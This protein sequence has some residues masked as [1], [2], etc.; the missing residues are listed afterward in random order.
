MISW[1]RRTSRRLL[2]GLPVLLLEISR[3]TGAAQVVLDGKFG[4]SGPVTGPNYAI[5]AG[6]GAVRG[7]NLFQSFS[8]FNLS[9]GEVATFSGPVG[10]QNILSRVTGG[11]P[12]SINGTIRSQIAGANFFLINPNGVIFGPSAAID[13]SGSFAAS[14]A[15]Y[16]KLA[17]GARFVASLDADDSGLSTAPVAAFGFLGPSAGGISVQQGTLSVLSGRTISLVG[18]D[19]AVDGG[20]IQSPQGRINVV[21]V[22]SAGEVP[23]DPAAMTVA[24]FNAA[25]PQQGQISF[26]NVARVDASGNGGGRIVIRGGRLT[27]DNS[28]VQSNTTG[29]GIGQGIDIAVV[30]D[31]NLFNLGQ[32][33]SLSTAGLGNGGNINISAQSILLN[34]G[35]LMDENFFP[36]TQISTATGDLFGGG[37]PGRGGDIVIQTGSLELVNSAQISSATFGL[38]DAGRIDITA[39]SVRLDAQLF[40]ATQIAANSQPFDGIGG[41]AGD[42][43]IRTDTLDILNGASLFAN[44]FGSGNG[45]NI[46]VQAKAINLTGYG[47]IT[48][49]TYGTGNGGNV[50][51]STDSLLVDSSFIQAVTTLN[52]PDPTLGR[53]GNVSINAGSIEVRNG[54]LISATTLGSGIGGTINV[55][56][57]SIRL[58]GDS[59]ASGAPTGIR[60]ASGQNLGG[61]VLV[62]TGNGGDIVIES[63]TPGAL[64]LIVTDGAQISTETLGSGDGG[65]IDISVSSLQLSRGGNISSA[66]SSSFVGAGVA[67]NVIVDAS[68]AVVLT[69]QALITTA[70]VNAQAGNISITA[71]SEVQIS[72]S[73]VTAQAGPGAAGRGGNIS[74]TADSINIA[75]GGLIS[76]TTLGDGAGGTINLAADS[77]QLTGD[78]GASGLPTGIRAAS[79]QNVGGFILVGTGN[80]GDIVIQSR[81]PG[82]LDLVVTDGAQISTETLGSGDGGRIDISA[83]SLQ[84]SSGGNISSASSDAGAAGNIT[85]TTSGSVVLTDQGLI[86]TAAPNAQGGDITVTAGDQIQLTDSQITAQAGPGGGGSITLSAPSMIYLLNSTLTAQA[87]GDG[88]NLSIIGPEFFIMNNSGLISKS[89]S[90]NGGNITILSAYFF[91]SGSTIDA[92][93]PFG[94]AGTVSV[95]AP[96]VDLSGSLVGLSGSLLDAESQLRPDC[97]VR[98]AGD[99]SSFIVLGRGGL[100][101]AP[102]GFVPSGVTTQ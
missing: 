30:N 84:L 18:G 100:P 19:I 5:T 80:G 94:L 91:Q 102:G 54:G 56:A 60:A 55:K 45:G 73:K 64:D 63:R 98:L 39:S 77:I 31:L 29:S 89:S 90:A 11:N 97:A 42:V 57:D 83:A 69:E 28:K 3:G 17:D 92:S 2:C 15:S 79:G 34:G 62:G 67:G 46:N 87:V 85:V 99:V 6:M 44:T 16:L 37:G 52:D 95:S 81:T 33:N 71:G 8:Q 21:S 36:A 26:Q 23:V 53:G 96:Q 40:T 43:V 61:S 4:S 78:N 38:G 35:G 93:A 20:V 49:A 70:A 76:A 82:A 25:F 32:I 1:R 59:G 74:I 51:I 68:D 10:I 12:S 9:A 101:I 13:V 75:N 7:N 48:P 58:T 66:S 14:T 47:L 41:D 88:G 72:D 24:Q 22:Q 86:T 27:V 50:S 65:R